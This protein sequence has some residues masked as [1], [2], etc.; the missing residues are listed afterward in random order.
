MELKS[1]ALPK[2]FARQLENIGTDEIKGSV[3]VYLSPDIT[4]PTIPCSI[5]TALQKQFLSSNIK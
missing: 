1:L 3:G 5:N 2:I 4:G